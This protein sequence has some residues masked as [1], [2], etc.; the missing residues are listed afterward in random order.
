[1][2]IKRGGQPELEVDMVVNRGEGAAKANRER[3]ALDTG[4]DSPATVLID[5]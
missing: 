2:T 1:M 5:Y 4:N 3:G